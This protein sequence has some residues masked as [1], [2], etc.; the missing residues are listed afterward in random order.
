MSMTPAVPPSHPLHRWFQGLVE[1]ALFTDVGICEPA[2]AD[3][4]SK[5]LTGFLHV[6]QIYLFRDANGKRLQEIGEMVERATAISGL[7]QVARRRR[8]HRHV[9]DY[10]LFWS[11]I[12]PESLRA[13]KGHSGG[14]CL[15]EYL[16]EGKRAYMIASELSEE[17]DVPPA[18]LFQQL[19]EDFEY[20]VYGLALVRRSWEAEDPEGYISIRDAL[21]A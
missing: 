12:Y 9:G 5:L 11:G 4:L 3:Y 21:G 18:R 1:N 10:A 13:R 6:D 2:V 20:C 15:K 16:G 19:S 7:S 14:D 8:I 17:Q